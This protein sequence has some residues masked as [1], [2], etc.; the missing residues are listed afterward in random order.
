MKSMAPFRNRM[1]ADT[2]VSLAGC[3]C[4][5]REH[6]RICLLPRYQLRRRGHAV[7]LSRRP[8]VRDWLSL[9][10][11]AATLFPRVIRYQHLQPGLFL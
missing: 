8:F 4:G 10:K 3:L 2:W 9:K 7:W 11:A 5:L 1:V 6:L